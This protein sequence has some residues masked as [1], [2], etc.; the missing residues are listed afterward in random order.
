MSL[1]QSTD[2]PVHF[3]ADPSCFSFD[4][5]VSEIFP[6]MALRAI[7]NFYQAHEA[8]VRM[9]KEHLFPGV[10]ILDI[11]ASRGA[12]FNAL[13][14]NYSDHWVSGAFAME[15]VDISQDMCDLMAAEMPEVY[16]R[17]G[18]ISS[19]DL[20][21]QHGQYDVVCLHYVLQF[22]P[23]AK[24]DYVLSRVIELVKPGGVFIY[25]H[26]AQHTGKVGAKAHEEYMRFRLGNGYSQEE[27]T[28]KTLALKSSMFPVNHEILMEKV[29]F[30]FSEVMETYKFMMFSTFFAIK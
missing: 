1:E 9:L 29:K 28:A 5:E 15:A 22:V 30:H 27:I 18:D 16:V 24:Q 25:G 26:K 10:K 13:K 21:L 4:K 23:P 8:H 12:F 11:G 2:R 3:P 7:P 19:P 14:Y 17:Q 6:N 20:T